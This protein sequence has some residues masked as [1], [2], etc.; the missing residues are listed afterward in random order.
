[1]HKAKRGLVLHEKVVR[2]QLERIV[3]DVGGPERLTAF[4][5]DWARQPI[6]Q[7]GL[8]LQNLQL[9]SYVAAM[10]GWLVAPLPFMRRRGVLRHAL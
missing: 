5:W 10:G 4:T 2:E 9:T 1:M 7:G 3:S 8:G 6:A